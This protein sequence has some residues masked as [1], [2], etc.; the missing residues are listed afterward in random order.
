[1][2]RIELRGD[3]GGSFRT[4][5]FMLSVVVS[6]NNVAAC[7]AADARNSGLKR[8]DRDGGGQNVQIS[9]APL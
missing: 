3:V 2:L 6:A 4:P 7:K 5:K 8:G 1:M 9:K